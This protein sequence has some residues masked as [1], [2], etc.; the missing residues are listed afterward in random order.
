LAYSL[1]S[2]EVQ[3]MT[4]IRY[5]SKHILLSVFLFMT[6]YAFQGCGAI[7]SG[8]DSTPPSVPTKLSMV[9]S[10]SQIGLSWMASTDNVGVIGYN[11]FR[12]GTHIGSVETSAALDS[13]VSSTTQYCYTVAAYDAAENESAP[14]TAICTTDS[15]TM[16]NSQCPV[17]PDTATGLTGVVMRGPIMP[18]C[19][20]TVPCDAP[21][22]AG[23]QIIENGVTIG[24][25]LSDTDGCFAI[26]VPPGSYE[27][28]PDA[29]SPILFPQSQ[30][31]AVTVGTAGW[32]QVELTFD[33]GIR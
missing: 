8:R 14:S 20:N 26:Q 5:M 27:V 4:A 25:F 15:S 21:F 12:D 23:F 13:D 19:S 10:T 6:A 9:R 33:T 29:G 2:K 28:V 30:T 22:S 18:V 3:K 7:N 31:Q 17:F 16:I 11:I 24:V 32:T 1:T